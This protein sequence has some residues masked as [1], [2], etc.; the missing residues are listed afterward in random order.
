MSGHFKLHHYAGT[1]DYNT[2]SFLDK[3]KDELPNEA[4]IFLLSSKSSLF[5]TLEYVPNEKVGIG[6]LGSCVI[7]ASMTMNY[8]RSLISRASVGS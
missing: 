1:I 5:H 4:T 7:N 6:S 2:N 3:I 8:S